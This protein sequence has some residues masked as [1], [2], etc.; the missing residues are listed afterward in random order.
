MLFLVIIPCFLY[1]KWGL[2]CICTSLGYW[3][4]LWL[5]LSI[6]SL[7]NVFQNSYLILPGNRSAQWIHISVWLCI[8]FCTFSSETLLPLLLVTFHSGGLLTELLYCDGAYVPQDSNDLVM[9]MGVF[10]QL[11][12]SNLTADI[13]Q[14]P[15][16]LSCPVLSDVLWFY[17]YGVS[18][19]KK[20]KNVFISLSTLS[21]AAKSL[22]E[23]RNPPTLSSWNEILLDGV[24]IMGFYCENMSCRDSLLT[25]RLAL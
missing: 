23:R 25:Q 8:W 18:C 20:K 15:L 17:D 21:H 24:I 2:I 19:F 7:L 5:S 14:V 22:L 16:T 10:D 13:F 1:Y 11:Y 4:S 6:F 9:E 3:F 12:Q